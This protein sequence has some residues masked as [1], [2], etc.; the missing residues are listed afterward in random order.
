MDCLSRTG[1]IGD[2]L[3]KRLQG[4]GFDV[5]A[6]LRCLEAKCR[7]STHPREF[8]GSREHGAPGPAS[9]LSTEQ[10]AEVLAKALRTLG[11]HE[12]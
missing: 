1:A 12:R 3:R 5:G 11:E 7:R 9:S 10:L 2:E 6:L 8:R 4:L